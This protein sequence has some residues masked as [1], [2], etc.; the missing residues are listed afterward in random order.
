MT[1]KLLQP[2]RMLRWRRV[3]TATAGIIGAL[4]LLAVLWPGPAKLLLPPPVVEPASPFASSVTFELANDLAVLRAV[5][6][7]SCDGDGEHVDVLSLKPSEEQRGGRSALLPRLPDGLACPGIMAIEE[8]ELDAVFDTPYRG[9]LDVHR[10]GGWGSFYLR[11]PRASAVV[12]LN[13]PRYP[14]PTTA[15]VLMGRSCGPLC[16]AGF[17]V[18]LTKRGDRWM[19]EEWRPAWMV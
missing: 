3:A 15:V 14:S 1:R 7:D 4:G 13:L 17:E 2:I 12:H 16:G 5:L 18:R 11:Y 10:I 6:E 19:V 9:A 8:E